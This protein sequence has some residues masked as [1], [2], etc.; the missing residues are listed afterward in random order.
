MTGSASCWYEKINKWFQN[1]K[2]DL[3]DGL[4]MMNYR[5]IHQ[6][7]HVQGIEEKGRRHFDNFPT[8]GSHWNVLTLISTCKTPTLDCHKNVLSVISLFTIKTPT[9]EIH[10]NN[11]KLF[12]S[13]FVSFCLFLL[14]LIKFYLMFYFSFVFPYSPEL[15]FCLFLRRIN[16]CISNLIYATVQCFIPIK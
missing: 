1:V 3:T 8:P 6:T 10:Y 2:T 12:I 13:W 16:T 9:S 11:F 5:S 4:M 14:F 15:N 7:I